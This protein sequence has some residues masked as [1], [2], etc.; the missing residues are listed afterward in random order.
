[1]SEEI[2]KKFKDN[3]DVLLE[4]TIDEFIEYCHNIGVSDPK[5]LTLNFLLLLKEAYIPATV[6]LHE[7]AIRNA[8][9][10]E[11]KN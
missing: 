8:I 3:F 6:N 9:N 11:T 5:H 1:M 7:T 10:N 2:I 4:K